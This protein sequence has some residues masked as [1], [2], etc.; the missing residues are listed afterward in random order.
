[1]T[2]DFARRLRSRQVIIGYWVVSDNPP[3]TERIAGAGYDY[4][5]LDLQHGFMDTAGALRSLTAID[6]GAAT[7]GSST[8]GVVRV[9]SNDAAAIGRA[10]DIGAAG[11]IVPLVNSAA[12]AE[13]AARAC[14]YPPR[15]ERSYGPLR[16]GSDPVQANDSVACIVMV[17]TAAGLEAVEAI[18]A[19]DGIDAVYVGPS[20]LGIAVGGARPA[21]GWA[22][23][24]WEPALARVRAAAAGAGI[25][26]GLHCTDGEKAAAAIAAGFTFASV[27][28]DLTH[29]DALVRRELSAVRRAA[30]LDAR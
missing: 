10:L 16:A 14:R 28:G 17:E 25:A 15:G 12:E 24:E 1:M 22:S 3:M 21:D 4:L 8:V 23:P 27:A 30:G 19:V 9:P 11:V 7:Q 29:I 6:A 13:A 18:C 26:S 2:T 5:C 20:D